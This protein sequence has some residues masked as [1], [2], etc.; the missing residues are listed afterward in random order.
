MSFPDNDDFVEDQPMAAPMIRSGE[1]Q[2][3]RGRLRG[4]SRKV[5]VAAGDK[6][7]QTRNKAG[8]ARDKTELFLRENPVPTILGAL[9][10]GLAIGFA[11]RYAASPEEK[12]EIRTP[13]GN[14]NGS[15]FSLPFLWPLLRSVRDKYEDSADAVR[16]GVDR[17]KNIDVDDYTKPIRKRWKSWMS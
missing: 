9:A 11:I 14:L 4:A 16:D 6:W 13:L 1:G 10:V 17:I 2:S 3:V 8:A 5:S 7:Q 15:F 12:R